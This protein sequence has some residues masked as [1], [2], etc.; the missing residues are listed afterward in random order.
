MKN[1][2]F[3]IIKKI[4][5][6]IKYN[7]PIQKI[8]MFISYFF[9]IL[10][11]IKNFIFNFNNVNGYYDL[12]KNPI[13][14]DFFNFLL[15]LEIERQIKKKKNIS[16]DIINID[17]IKPEFFREDINKLEAFSE[18]FRFFN[19]NTQS[20][21]LFQHV[22]NIK[23]SKKKS[24]HFIKKS[25]LNT[26]NYDVKNCEEYIVSNFNKIIEDPLNFESSDY[27]VFKDW[28]NKNKFNSNRIVTISLRNVKR[29]SERNSDLNVWM[30]FYDFI[31]QYNFQPIIIYD[32]EGKNNFDNFNRRELC[33]IASSDF[34]K[35]IIFYKYS[36]LNAFVGQGPATCNIVM[37]TNYIYCQNNKKHPLENESRY[38]KLKNFENK[39]LFRHIIYE[40]Q[41]IDELKLTF[42]KFVEF[43]EKNNL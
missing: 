18:R 37:G 28:C 20:L 17:R 19:M 40:N 27:K 8:A 6:I 31:L 43:F 35:R 14:N 26:Y 7:I 21:K 10:K 1:L 5:S 11:I 30:E 3:K 33:E 12:N 32:F 29:N 22:N 9:L 2:I 24:L 36:A 39:E 34:F 15:F 42:D 25:Y 41:N 13:S 4:I 38:L 23:I 16:L